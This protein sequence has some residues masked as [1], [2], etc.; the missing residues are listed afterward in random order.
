MLDSLIPPLPETR[1]TM[2]INH[3][4][5]NVFASP[6]T[7]VS[8]LSVIR[9]RTG[10]NRFLS[11]ISCGYCLHKGCR[12]N[13]CQHMLGEQLTDITCQKQLKTHS[14]LTSIDWHLLP[15]FPSGHL[16]MS[17]TTI[18]IKPHQSTSQSSSTY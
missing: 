15:L 10:M 8:S 3:S 6:D 13:L 4:R 5:C 17:Q 16:C 2:S 9:T 1:S 14:G 18:L 11:H 12:S 7:F